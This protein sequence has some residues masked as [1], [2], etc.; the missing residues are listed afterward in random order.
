MVQQLLDEFSLLEVEGSHAQ[1]FVRPS[2]HV[3][4]D[5]VDHHRSLAR[6]A[7]VLEDSVPDRMILDAKIFVFVI[8]RWEDHQVAL[9][10]L[11]I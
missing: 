6:I 7:T 9:V 3:I 4:H 10:E 1:G 2:L 5:R 8:C 11:L